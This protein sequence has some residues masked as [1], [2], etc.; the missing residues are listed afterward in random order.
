M[1][2]MA[3]PAIA[4]SPLM[5]LLD[6]NKDGSVAI[7]E[8]KAAAAAAFERIK[9]VSPEAMFVHKGAM[10][11]F[12]SKF[13]AL[14]MKWFDIAD[15]NKNGRLDEEELAAPAGKKLGKLLTMDEAVEAQP[16]KPSPQ[17]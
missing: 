3:S 10:E 13:I 9:N 4:A 17:P 14:V 1:T 15:L 7:D 12:R 8:I 2:S 5:V 16:Q 11:H 6:T